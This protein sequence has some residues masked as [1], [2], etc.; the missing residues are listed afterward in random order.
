MGREFLN[1]DAQQLKDLAKCLPLANLCC[2]ATFLVNR[3]II[4][5]LNGVLMIAILTMPFHVYCMWG[6]IMLAAFS[7][8][9]KT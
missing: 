6:H 8:K 4:Q 9:F 1:V 3:E 2:I 7:V 5:D